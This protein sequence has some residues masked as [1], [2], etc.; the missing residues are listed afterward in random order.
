[1]IKKETMGSYT[2]PKTGLK[3]VM[4]KTADEKIRGVIKIKVTK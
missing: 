4:V 1:M 2:D 3:L